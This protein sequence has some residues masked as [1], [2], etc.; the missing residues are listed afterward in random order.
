[1]DE[2]NDFNGPLYVIPGSHKIGIVDF[3]SE[4]KESDVMAANNDF[5]DSLSANLEFTINQKVIT[6]WYEQKGI[7]AAK[8]KPGTCMIFHGNIFHASNCNLSP[9]DRKVFII[10][11]NSVSNTPVEVQNQR[12]DYLC[13]RDFKPL[14]VV[15]N[16]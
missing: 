3:E 2:V 4:Q 7:F 9:I 13:S 15:F 6:K 14:N 11:Y 1:L 8:G 12:P 10:T 5:T 16:F